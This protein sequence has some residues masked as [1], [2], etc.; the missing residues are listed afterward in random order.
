MQ[1]KGGGYRNRLWD[2]M[3]GIWVLKNRQTPVFL[4]GA[5]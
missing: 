4:E 1:P 2:L 5:H 3:P